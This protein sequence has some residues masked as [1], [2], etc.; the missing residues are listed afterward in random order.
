MCGS[1]NAP[2][3][4][5]ARLPTI[6]VVVVGRGRGL[7]RMLLMPLLA[8]LSAILGAMDGNIG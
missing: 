1:Y 7:V 4:G 5:A 3:V 6:V 2:R 8:A